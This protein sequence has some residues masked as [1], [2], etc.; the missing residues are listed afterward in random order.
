MRT[1]QYTISGMACAACSSTV[2]RVVSRLD[3][4]VSCD[5]NLITGGMSVTFDEHRCGASDFIRVVEKAGFGIEQRQ[6][7]AAATP[8]KPHPSPSRRAP[9]ALLVA[10]V[11][12]TLL[13]Y[14][15][16]GPMVFD[17]L[18]IP[19][20]LNM[21]TH[22]YNYALAQLL[23]TLPALFVGRSF[24]SKGLPLLFRG[25]PNMDSLVAVGAGAALIYSI[26]TTFTIGNDPHAVHHLYF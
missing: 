2:R 26:V 1:E 12:S 25:H 6:E 15:S 22:P 10:I 16:M 8:K 14:L 3:G 24:F 13:L 20:F 21:D 4:V 9:L 19:S 23:L 7:T 5:V 17:R 11:F 18:P